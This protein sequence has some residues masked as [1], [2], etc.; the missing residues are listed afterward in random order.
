MSVDGRVEIIFTTFTFLVFV[1]EYLS[2]VMWGRAGERVVC[3]LLPMLD[4]PQ[5]INMCSIVKLGKWQV[6]QN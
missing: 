6:K 2:S 5:G 1:S 4:I 3:F